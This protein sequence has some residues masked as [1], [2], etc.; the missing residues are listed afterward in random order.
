MIEQQL[1][2]VRRT[3][4]ITI[5]FATAVHLIIV[6]T[7]SLIFLCLTKFSFIGESWHTIAQLQSRDVLPVLQAS[8]LMRDD[9]VGAWLQERDVKE[10][11]MSLAG[12]F[13]GDNAHIV[14]RRVPASPNMI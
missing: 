11:R 3:G 6:A 5:T 9:E 13:P 14:K 8:N 2:P 7:V 4:L 12:S 10:E 1:Q